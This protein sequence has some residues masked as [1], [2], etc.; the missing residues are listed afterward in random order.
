M[1][2][3]QNPTYNHAQMKQQVGVSNLKMLDGEDLTAGDRRKLQQL[4]M[5]DWVQQQTQENQAKKQL[6]KQIQ[7]QYDQQTLQIN[8]ALKDLDQEQQRRRVEMEIANQ[9]INNQMAQEK[10][11]REQYMAA[12][13]Q[14][15]KK[16]HQQEIMNNDVWT[17]NT[18]TCQSALA[19]H[20]VIPYHYKGM[21]EEQRQQIRNDQAKQRQENEQKKQQEKEDE[22][23]WAQYN[24]HNRKQL[25][26]QEREK[27]RKLQTLRNNQKEFNLLSQTEQKLKLK[28]EYA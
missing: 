3:Y 6:N 28:N 14:Q 8:Q 9:Q 2:H 23:M 24:E 18:A 11:D 4:Q 20:R 21:S 5:R 12:L 1:S 13:A 19:P 25:I 16:Q 7:Q 27:A 17:E 26:I 15:E 22:K 10:Q